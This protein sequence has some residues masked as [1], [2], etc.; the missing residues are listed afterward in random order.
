MKRMFNYLVLATLWIISSCIHETNINNELYPVLVGEYY[1]FIDS[2]GNIAIEP[3]FDYVDHFSDG[4]CYAMIANRRGLINKEGDFI[5]EFPDSLHYSDDIIADLILV[6][7]E[8]TSGI[9]NKDGDIIFSTD[10]DKYIEINQD[11]S[12][13]YFCVEGDSGDDGNASWIMV[14]TNGKSIGEPCDSIVLGFSK[15]LCAVKKNSK[16]GYMDKNG[17]CV[18][19][20]KYDY[21]R[22]FSENG[23]ARVRRGH[24]HYF[25]DTNGCERIKVEYAIRGFHQNRA[26]V[27]LNGEKCFIDNNGVKICTIDAD[28]VY[29]YDTEGFSTVI[30]NGKTSKID[31]TGAIVFTSNY[32][33]IGDFINGTAPVR[34]DKQWGLIDINGKELIKP[35][36]D[37]YEFN[38]QNIICFS[39]S[40]FIISNGGIN[41][42]T[43]VV[44][45]YDPHGNIIWKDIYKP[46][47]I[48]KGT[49]RQDFIDYIDSKMVDI[50]PI[51]GIYYVRMTV[52]EV[53]RYTKNLIPITSDSWFEALL[54]DQN[55]IFQSYSIGENSYQL[56][57]KFIQIGKTN[58]YAVIRGDAFSSGTELTLD[59]ITKFEFIMYDD[60]Y[61]AF[62]KFQYTK[63]YPSKS[64]TE[65]I[66][67][68]E[69]TGSGF[70]IADGYIATNYHVTEGAKTITIRGIDGNMERRFVGYVVASDKDNDISI[71]K[72]IDKDFKGMETIP[73]KIGN[74]SVSVGDDVFVLGYPMTTTMGEEV[75]LTNGIISSSTGYKGDQSMYQISAAVQ[76][77]NSGGPLF[78]SEGVVIGIVCGKHAE[79]E[80][81]NY[82]VKISNLNRLLS[83]SGFDIKLANSNKLSRKDLSRQVKKAKNFVYLIECSSK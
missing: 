65:K 15:G 16:W 23:L 11:G 68:S 73:Y 64:V 33:F 22:A 32:D 50:D 19:E 2:E 72:I 62:I 43:H 26:L 9:I 37:Y 58:N 59:D 81:V 51:E 12:N 7:S 6:D 79:G 47:S 70:A 48:L 31:T 5:Y 57:N 69:W 55:N 45:Y 42:Y 76:P 71:L 10:S 67:Q 8:H 52:G 34:K 82:A 36:H 39:D 27:I 53:D 46:Q 80:N 17:N 30:K 18:I 61:S 35:S 1:G 44:T 14:D 49:N 38:T 75:K 28:K 4:I 13:L 21:A 74:T 83:S 41:T 60:N 24:E 25:I 77:G 40:A 66:E 56:P 29:S 63:D 3:Q 78:N 20:C 54:S